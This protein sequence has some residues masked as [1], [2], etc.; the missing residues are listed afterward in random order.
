MY[1]EGLILFREFYNDE[2][3]RLIGLTVS[4]LSDLKIHQLTFL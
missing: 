3:I 2:K 1:R 4:N